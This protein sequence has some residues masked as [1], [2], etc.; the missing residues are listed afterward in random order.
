MGWFPTN[1]QAE[2]K[3]FGLNAFWGPYSIGFFA[4][5]TIE[6]SMV[7]IDLNGHSIAM[8]DTFYLRTMA[9]FVLIVLSMLL[10]NTR[11]C[12]VTGHFIGTG[13]CD[14]GP[15]EPLQKIS[16]EN[17]QISLL[18]TG[19]NSTNNAWIENT[20]TSGTFIEI[21]HCTKDTLASSVYGSPIYDCITMSRNDMTGGANVILKYSFAADCS[22]F[23]KL[24]QILPGASVDTNG[25]K[26][27][28]VI[29]KIT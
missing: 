19:D 23:D 14:H 27:M 8:H 2:H 25:K 20:V 9:T 5:I 26:Q 11:S 18:S 12:D 22:S 13:I 7:W 6:H 3:Y 17:N 28:P 29:C 16:G 1:E 24:V 4:G 15:N 10:Y 21:E